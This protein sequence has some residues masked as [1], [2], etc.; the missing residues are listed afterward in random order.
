ML[1]QANQT[2]AR[3]LV[4]SSQVVPPMNESCN[5]AA[6]LHCGICGRWFCAVHVEEET[7]HT[8]VLERGDEA[9]WLNFLR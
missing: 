2:E 5:S 9:V 3:D 8:C 7:W 6:T 4:W 1:Q